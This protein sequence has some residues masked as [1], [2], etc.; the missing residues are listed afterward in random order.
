[1]K[2]CRLIVGL[3]CR[4]SDLKLLAGK[5]AESLSSWDIK[6]SSHRRMEDGLLRNSSQ[7][8]LPR[9]VRCTCIVPKWGEMYMYIYMF[10]YSQDIFEA[11]LL[12]SLGFVSPVPVSTCLTSALD[13]RRCGGSP[14]TRSYCQRT[15]KCKS[16]AAV[17]N[18]TRPSV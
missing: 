18:P 12:A 7:H 9:Q 13:Q 4:A 14:S 8:G 10:V 1:M 2:A 16:K 3:G 6:A 15:S 11:N 5:L 17:R